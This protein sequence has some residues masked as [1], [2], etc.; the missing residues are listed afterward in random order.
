MSAIL[1]CTAAERRKIFA[2]STFIRMETTGITP[3][4]TRVSR[5]LMDS[6]NPKHPTV[7]MTV[8]TG[9][10]TPGPSTIRTAFMSCAP[11]ER[12]SPTR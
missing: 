4:A 2:P 12:M 9:Y 10:M 6:M 7:V 1:A 8:S 5:G 3:S 11:R